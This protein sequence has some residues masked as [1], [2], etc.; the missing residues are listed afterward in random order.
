MAKWISRIVRTP[1]LLI[2]HR[3]GLPF[4]ISK[5]LINR[6]L[7]VEIGKQ[8]VNASKHDFPKI[9][10]DLLKLKVKDFP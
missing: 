1:V 10:Q 9:N 8:A 6:G 2:A 4:Q 3:L 5:Q 7:I